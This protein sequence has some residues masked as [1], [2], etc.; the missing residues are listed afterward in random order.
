LIYN[1]DKQ[2]FNIKLKGIDGFEEIVS[3]PIYSLSS[4]TLEEA[5]KTYVSRYSRY[6]RS[7]NRRKRKFEKRLYRDRTKLK[8]SRIDS[9]KRKWSS[10]Q[11]NYMSEEEK[12]LSKEEWLIY[13]D[14][15]IANERK[16]L[17]N[18]SANIENIDRSITLDGYTKTFLWRDSPQNNPPVSKAARIE[19]IKTL[20]Q[21]QDSNMLA[22]KQVLVLDRTTK[23][24]QRYQ[25]SL[26][27]K[28][29]RLNLIEGNNNVIIT[30]LRNDDIGYVTGNEYQSI[31]FP[32][33]NKYKFTLKK[34]DAKFGS[35][36][37]IREELNF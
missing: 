12:K 11:K 2:N 36:Q 13:Y 33:N 8:R 27:I 10:F 16:A 5:Q 32:K 19:S 15:V 9:E 20:Y 17:G 30:Q 4:R 34:I 3:Y 14:K 26:G 23:T 21:D 25:G 18:A 29:I 35:V 31:R 22:I 1:N 6:D 7:L 24:Y 37:T 28:M